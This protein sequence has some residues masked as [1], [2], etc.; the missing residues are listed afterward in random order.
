MTRTHKKAG[1]LVVAPVAT[2]VR[3]SLPQISSTSKH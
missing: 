3:V 2:D 1:K